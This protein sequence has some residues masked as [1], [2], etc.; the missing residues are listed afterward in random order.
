MNVLVTGGLGFV[1]SNLIPALKKEGHDVRVLDNLCIKSPE[2]ISKNYFELVV[3][4]IRNVSDVKKALNNI[5]A[6]IHLA[7]FGSVIDSIS[8]PK[9]NFDNNVFGTFNLLNQ[10]MR[11][12]IKKFIFAS[13]GGALIGNSSKQ[14]NEASLPKPISPYGSSKLCAEAYFSSYSHSY[15]MDII[16]LRFANIIGPYSWHKKGVI[17]KFIKNIFEGEPLTIFGDG[18]SSRDYL[19]V[20]DLIEGISKSLSKEIKG[21]TPIHLSSGIETSINQVAKKLLEISGRNNYKIEYRDFRK[22]EVSRNFANF[23]TAENLLNF[24]PKYDIDIALGLTWKWFHAFKDK[25]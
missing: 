10:A 5:D 2:Y 23:S 12:G 21:F 14:V 8:R 6:V 20:G 7:A 22:G 18:S 15:D 24:F 9:E 19:F 25:V 16:S 17:T 3:G 1:G 4:D 13:T 11:T